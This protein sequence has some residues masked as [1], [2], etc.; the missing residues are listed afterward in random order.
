M[1]KL[2]HRITDL[3]ESFSSGARLSSHEGEAIRLLSGAAIPDPEPR[4]R[5]VAESPLKID[6]V[7]LKR[8]VDLRTAG[9]GV[10]RGV[11]VVV[12]LLSP[13]QGSF[14]MLARRQ[15]LASHVQPCC[16]VSQ[17]GSAR[18]FP[19]R[20]RLSSISQRRPTECHAAAA[21]PI[22]T[23]APMCVGT[24]C[25]SELSRVPSCQGH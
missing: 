8:E 13:Y 22:E 7:V 20:L 12:G 11:Q 18:T 4:S 1:P 23:V 15:V 21:P 9:I 6:F 25:C 10:L 19:A 2:T 16:S 5:C 3:S 14:E 17:P 24:C